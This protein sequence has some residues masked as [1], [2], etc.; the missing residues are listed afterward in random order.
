MDKVRKPKPVQ[1]SCFDFPG[2]RVFAGKYEIVRFVGAGWQGEV[3]HDFL[4][5][6]AGKRLPV[7]DGLHLLHA[8]ARGVE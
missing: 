3:L 4:R 7:F 5:K 1:I 6:H 8:L 2:G